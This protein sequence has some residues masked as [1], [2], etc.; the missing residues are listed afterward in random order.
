MNSHGVDA[1]RV[2]SGEFLTLG[3]R[4]WRVDQA[5]EQ[6]GIHPTQKLVGLFL[7]PFFFH[8]GPNDICC[9][10]FLGSGTQFIACEQTSI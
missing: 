7:R 6:T 1:A 9:E 3:P 4:V 8:T 5:G 2:R 10:P